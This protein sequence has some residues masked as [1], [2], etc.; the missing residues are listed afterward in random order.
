MQETHPLR[1]FPDG[2]DEH[3]TSNLKVDGSS[4]SGVTVKPVGTNKVPTGF[5]FLFDVLVGLTGP[6]KC[7]FQPRLSLRMRAVMLPTVMP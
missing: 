6:D 2:D 3:V 1:V 7:G 4:P 5:L